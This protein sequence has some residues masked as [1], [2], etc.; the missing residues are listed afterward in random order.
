M[1]GPRGVTDRRPPAG[2]W[3]QDERGLGAFAGSW[4]CVSE[5]GGRAPVLWPLA[6]QLLNQFENTGPPP[7]DK[8]KIQALPTVPVTEEHVGTRPSVTQFPCFS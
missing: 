2:V 7:A 3:A 4:P 1:A 5:S 8:E 6:F